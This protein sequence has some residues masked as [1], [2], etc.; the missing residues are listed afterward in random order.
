MTSS[1]NNNKDYYNIFRQLT[2]GSQL[3]FDN[4]NYKTLTSI[5][6]SFFRIQKE[7]LEVIERR[8]DA[9]ESHLNLLGENDKKQDE[10][11]AIIETSLPNLDGKLKALELA[12][13]FFQ[14]N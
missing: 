7:V 14:V 12:D 2:F 4:F 8:L 3:L 13:E 5:F 10:T 1:Q 11:I 9:N 6:C